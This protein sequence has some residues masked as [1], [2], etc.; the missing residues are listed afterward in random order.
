MKEQDKFLQK[1]KNG[2][3]SNSY[4]FNDQNIGAKQY[5]LINQE[6]F[7]VTLDTTLRYHL[8]NAETY[9]LA[10]DRNPRGHILYFDVVT[11]EL[12]KYSG[13]FDAFYSTR[14]TIKRV[15]HLH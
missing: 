9:Y 10:S 14:I 7:K 11:P 8:P 3:L 12:N 1:R 2:K 15:Y 4:I 6:I 5:Q 13:A